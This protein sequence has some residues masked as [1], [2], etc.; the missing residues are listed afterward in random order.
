MLF[1][2]FRFVLFPLSERPIL[3]HVPETIDAHEGKVV[4]VLNWALSR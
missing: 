4:P 1:S 2:H 3:T